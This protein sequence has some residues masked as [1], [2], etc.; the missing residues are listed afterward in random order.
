[1]D[2]LAAGCAQT[3]I[4]CHGQQALSKNPAWAK[5]PL[6]QSLQK[7]ESSWTTQAPQ[8]DNPREHSGF[9]TAQT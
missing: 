1:M 8:E 6:S 4:S 3:V 9:I 5:I 7:R 2:Y